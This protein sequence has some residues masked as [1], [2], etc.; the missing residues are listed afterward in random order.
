M[1]RTPVGRSLTLGDDCPPPG[2]GEYD[3]GHMNQL[4]VRIHGGGPS[5][6]ISLRTQLPAAAAA[7]WRTSSESPGPLA[8]SPRCLSSRSAAPTGQSMPAYSMPHTQRFDSSSTIGPGPSGYEN[9]TSSMRTQGTSFTKTKQRDDT[10]FFGEEYS[11]E[12][13]GKH[14]PGPMASPV[15]A[16]AE[17]EVHVR[18]S[19]SKCVAA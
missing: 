4:G 5:Y 17:G 6:S 10:R 8:Y 13:Y 12:N 14:S 11:R 18:A 1:V 3:T 19:A 2:P 16:R 9:R 7:H 15:R